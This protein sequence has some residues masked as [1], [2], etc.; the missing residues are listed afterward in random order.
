MTFYILKTPILDTK[1][2]IIELLIWFEHLKSL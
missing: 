1:G 2:V